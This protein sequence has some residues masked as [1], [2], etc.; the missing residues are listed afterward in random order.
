MLDLMSRLQALPDEQRVFGLTSHFRLCL[1]AKDD[2]VSPWLVI[3]SA[4]DKHNYFI[5]YLMPDNV[6]PWPGAYV[7]GQ[8]NSED[9]AVRMIMIA[10]E[11]SGGWR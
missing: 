2:Y 9:D 3:I 8:A 7:R 11:K 6:A 1:L 10:M 4:L 5:E